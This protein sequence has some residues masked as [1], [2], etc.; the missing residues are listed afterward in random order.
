MPYSPA[1]TVTIREPIAQP[2]GYLDAPPDEKMGMLVLA[3]GAQL[4][5]LVHAYVVEV[6]END[7]VEVFDLTLADGRVVYCIPYAS[8]TCCQSP[9]EYDGTMGSI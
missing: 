1:I 6:K 4:S 7:L 5:G 9:S 2:I 3:P 8:V